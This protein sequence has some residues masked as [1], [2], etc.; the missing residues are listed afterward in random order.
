MKK[1]AGSGSAPDKLSDCA[2]YRN[3]TQA[4]PMARLRR[5]SP[6]QR[7]LMLALFAWALL[8]RLLVPAGWMP[9]ADA[10]GPHLVL[11]D[12]GAA[13][14]PAHDMGHGKA[15][16]HHQGPSD[17]PCSFAGPVAAVET[18]LAAVPLPQAAPR[19]AVAAVHRDVAIGRGLAAPPPPPTGPPAFA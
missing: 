17:H 11:C 12:G 4:E 19:Y 3:R 5:L 10:A 1:W 14:M 13:A 15:P 6:L 7:R 9:A 18:P 16:M 8:V 2:P